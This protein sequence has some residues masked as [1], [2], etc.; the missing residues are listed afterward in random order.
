M[1]ALLSSS[2]AMLWVSLMESLNR[3]SLARSFLEYRLHLSLSQRDKFKAEPREGFCN[4]W[5]QKTTS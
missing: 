2:S 5:R 3:R 1:A 4:D